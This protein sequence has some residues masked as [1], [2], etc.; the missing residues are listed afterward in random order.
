SE[1]VK[2]RLVDCCSTFLQLLCAPHVRDGQRAIVRGDS[3]D[4]CALI[5]KRRRARTLSAA[6]RVAAGHIGAPMLRHCPSGGSPSRRRTALADLSRESIDSPK[7]TDL[8][9]AL[10]GTERVESY[11]LHKTK[12]QSR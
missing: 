4:E 12:G 5:Q 1:A 11:A 6:A 7:E 9:H 3:R 10:T 2:S 8:H